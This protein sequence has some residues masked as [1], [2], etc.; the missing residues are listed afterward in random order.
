MIEKHTIKNIVR[1]IKIGDHVKVTWEDHWE[2]TGEAMTL[3]EIKEKCSKPCVG[4]ATGFVM[5]N[6]RKVLVIVSNQWPDDDP[7]TFD[8]SIFT[9]IK[10]NITEL[11]V[12]D[13]V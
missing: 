4:K 3:S 5:V 2:I 8:G 11:K 9:I 7:P 6:N 12:L 10:K 1:R 13:D